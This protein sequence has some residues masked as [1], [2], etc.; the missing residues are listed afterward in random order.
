MPPDCHR[1]V[2]LALLLPPLRLCHIT[3]SR[4]GDTA[5]ISILGLWRRGRE[6]LRWGA[7]GSWHL[8][9]N[10][11]LGPTFLASPH[12]AFLVLHFPLGTV[13]TAVIR[14]TIIPA[15]LE[16]L[17]LF[18]PP[19]GRFHPTP[20]HGYRRDAGDPPAAQP[21]AG[22]PALLW[23]R[24]PAVSGASCEPCP[25]PRGCPSCQHDAAAGPQASA[26][27]RG[28]P[29]GTGHGSAQAVLREGS[30]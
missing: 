25:V 15:E 27:S 24:P 2:P 29:E 19:F 21:S 26:G 16:H 18:L 30:R 6:K 11:T 9:P 13:I 1:H 12:G 5:G 3:M 28:L 10:P 17:N 7:G 20:A 4:A 22:S 8:P 23:V 14:K